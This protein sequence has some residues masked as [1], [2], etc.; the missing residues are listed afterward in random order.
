MTFLGV[1]Q[2]LYSHKHKQLQAILTAK[3]LLAAAP[4][5]QFFLFQRPAL[6]LIRG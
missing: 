5:M 2:L 6:A 4:P 1:N 3:A